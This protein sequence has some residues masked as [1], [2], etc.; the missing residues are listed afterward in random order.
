MDKD[1]WPFLAVGVTIAYETYVAGR[2]YVRSWAIRQPVKTNLIHIQSWAEINQMAL[3]AGNYKSRLTAHLVCRQDLGPVR[4]VIRSQQG[5]SKFQFM[6][7]VCS[8]RLRDGRQIRRPLE[9]STFLLPDNMPALYAIMLQVLFCQKRLPFEGKVFVPG[10]LSA[11]NYWIRQDA[12]YW[13]TSLKEVLSLTP[14]G[15]LQTL[16]TDDTEV[17][18]VKSGRPR[19]RTLC[20]K[21]W[22]MRKSPS[23]STDLSAKEV[24]QVFRDVVVWGHIISPLPHEQVNGSIILIGG[25]GQ[26]DRF[27]HAGKMDL[28]YRDLLEHLARQGFVCLQYDKPGSGRTPTI[29]S[30]HKP[31][32]QTELRLARHW[33]NWLRKRNGFSGHLFL[34]GHSQGGQ[35]ALKIASEN[36]PVSGVCLLATIGRPIQ[37]VLAGQIRKQVSD[38]GLNKRI[39]EHR[40][41]T[42]RRFFSWIKRSRRN[43]LPP[44]EFRSF[45]HIIP[46]YRDL[47]DLSP[48]HLLPRV[49]APILIV[50]GDKDIQVAVSDSVCLEKIAATA[51]ILVT[52]ATIR[53]VD[54][55]FKI[56]KGET[57][58]GR[59]ADRR[60]RFSKHAATTIT[61]WLVSA[62]SLR[63]NL[64][65]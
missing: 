10:T 32:L 44:E 37:E 42:L 30:L 38:L 17:V 3:N 60:R 46:W 65:K 45:T 63:D 51:G 62:A 23:V 50:Q 12:S 56:S 14:T 16:H 52:R 39:G 34:I 28:G 2:L 22:T 5:Q 55:L 31:R 43:A 35:I 36:P 41:H 8:V 57:N 21:R 25:S 64:V 47:A 33:A 40:I 58:I 4:L 7:N 27:G 1:P 49:R 48:E 61:K 9:N 54:H 18:A 29:G 6:D 20:L 53:G 24:K 19:W 15:C 59:Y 26:H 11:L 13:R